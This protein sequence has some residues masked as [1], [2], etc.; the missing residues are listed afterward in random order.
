MNEKKLTWNRVITS[1][2]ALVRVM[3]K[4]FTESKSRGSDYTMVKSVSTKNMLLHL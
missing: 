2:F 4:P 3:A 1:H